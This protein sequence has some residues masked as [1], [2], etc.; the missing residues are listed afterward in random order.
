MLL[1]LLFL[2]VI[3]AAASTPS[4]C[5]SSPQNASWPPS[6]EWSALNKSIDGV[7]IKTS[8]APSSCY[9]G[10]PFNSPEDCTDVSK[11]W[12]YAKYHAA[13]PESVDYSLYTNN[14]CLPPGVEGYVEERGCSIGGLPQYIVNVTKEEQV[15]TALE[16]ASKRN[17]R[18]V[19]K[20]TGHDLSGRSTGAYSLSIWTRNL[21]HAEHQPAWRLPGRNST[22]DVMIFGSGNN[23]GSAYTA[24]H[25]VN[26]TVV[27]GED[28]TVGLGGLI[29][30]G[31]H[32]LLSSTYGLASDQLHQATVITTD[33]Q[34]LIANTVTN[35]DL[36]WA[37]RGGGG[38]QFG[39]VT[40]F[41]LETHPVPSD[42]VSGG[43]SYYI[44]QG[45]NVSNYNSWAALAEVAS[46]IPDLMDSGLTGSIMALTGAEAAT[47][48]GLNES[49]TGPAA[50]LSF[51]GFNST[52]ERMNATVNGL[53]SKIR[54]AAGG[55]VTVLAQPPSAKTY[56]E[57]TKPNPLSSQL[58]GSS[59]LTTSRLLGRKELTNIA[60]E[61]LIL[62]LQQILESGGEAGSMALFG[63]QGGQGTARTPQERRGSVHPAW[64]TAYT[65][66]M[67]YG[68][69]INATAD[70]AKAL[71]TG[72]EWYETTIE[73]VWR[74][75]TPAG[76]SYM[77][78]GNVF[79]STW[80][81]DFY[82]ENYDRLLEIKR[83]YD[84]SESLFVWG[85]VGSDMW[86]Y[87]L[88]SGLLCRKSMTYK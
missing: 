65:H 42:V 2:A 59:G 61:D 24:V 68:A 30:N 63:L 82:G 12:T 32:G 53:A 50:I 57:S 74:N 14:S 69:P 51:I 35:Q 64:R 45:S 27:G 60:K 5:K 38:G 34:R 88:N 78:E 77:N 29:Q 70:A 19:V 13:W 87:D 56:W 36:F 3:A 73:P 66:L 76:G 40:E 80:K 10:N 16:W 47:Y 18:V 83:K 37:I 55:P 43:F 39:V 20:G 75:W 58:S 28:A 21:N 6:E 17:I 72:A 11:Y 67:T 81:Q 15:A 48:L 26:R 4:D 54:R 49:I 25:Q 1:Y 7:L 46:Q 85:G 44:S 33:G 23:W 9:P 84:P 22:A 31:G 52:V 41:V 8:P 79:S 71:A 62:Y 86:D